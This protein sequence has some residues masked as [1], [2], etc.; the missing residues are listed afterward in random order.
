VLVEIGSGSRDLERDGLSFTRLILWQFWV[1]FYY[2]E[3]WCVAGIALSSGIICR[4]SFPNVL[5]ALD[6]SGDANATTVL[7]FSG[8]GEFILAACGCVRIDRTTSTMSKK[9]IDAWQTVSEYVGIFN[10]LVVHS[11]PRAS[12]FSVFSSC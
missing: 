12:I 5:P 6:S 8:W 11:L 10:N 4:S 1:K 7:I 3:I 2:W 9:N